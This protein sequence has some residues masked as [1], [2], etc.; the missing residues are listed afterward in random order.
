[1]NARSQGSTPF[2]SYFSTLSASW[3]TFFGRLAPF[4]SHFLALSTRI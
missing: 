1:V 2:Y 3:F 4:G